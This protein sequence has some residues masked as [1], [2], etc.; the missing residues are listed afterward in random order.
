MDDDTKTLINH[1]D[2]VVDKMLHEEISK[3]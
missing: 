3:L 2:G 1:P